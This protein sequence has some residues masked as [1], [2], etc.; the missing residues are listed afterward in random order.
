[1][2]DGP[3]HNTIHACSH[4]I[5][6]LDLGGTGSLS[7]TVRTAFCLYSSHGVRCCRRRDADMDGNRGS[8]S[9]QSVMPRSASATD[10]HNVRVIRRMWC[11][12]VGEG[13]NRMKHTCHNVIN[14]VDACVMST[15]ARLAAWFDSH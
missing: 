13:I 7:A 5:K 4:R 9:P 10:V 14:V 8:V 1:M 2:T 11:V 3:A 12:C 15:T 6:S